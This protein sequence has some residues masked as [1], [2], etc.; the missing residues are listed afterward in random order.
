VNQLALGNPEIYNTFE[1]VSQPAKTDP[2][3]VEYDQSATAHLRNQIRA[4][5]IALGSTLT[6]DDIF[7]RA[8]TQTCGGCH[9]VSNGTPLGHGIVWP[10]SNGFTQIDEAGTLSPALT[11]DFIPHRKHVLHDFV[12]NGGAMA[13]PGETIGG[14][15]LGAAN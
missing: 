2:T 11:S 3:S 12:C 14:E 1:S 7:R 4:R 10:S 5:L 6:V 13:A 8:T 15:P 9:D